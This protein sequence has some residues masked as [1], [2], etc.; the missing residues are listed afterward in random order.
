MKR[1]GVIELKNSK[2]GIFDHRRQVSPAGGNFEEPV[3]QA[4]LAIVGAFHGLSRARSDARRYP[5]VDPLISWSKYLNKV[6]VELEE[7]FHGW[8]E[9][10]QD[11]ERDIAQ[12]R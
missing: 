7:N 3:T 12:R 2:N 9:K 11:V 4:S 8:A 1:S 6:G 10:V 5:A